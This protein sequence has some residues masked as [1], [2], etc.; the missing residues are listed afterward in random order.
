V[1]GCARVRT[2]EYQ[3]F[4][5]VALGSA[6]EDRYPLGVVVVLG[7]LKPDDVAACRESSD[8]VVRELQNLLEAR[9]Y[10]I[11]SFCFASGR[12]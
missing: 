8:H 3:R 5:G 9:R 10:L 1:E 2:R 11:P 4:V 6:T 7:D 12:A